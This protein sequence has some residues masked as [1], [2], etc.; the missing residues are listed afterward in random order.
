M[1]K[2]LLAAVS[3]SALIACNPEKDMVEAVV[4]DTG[5]I[6]GAG[7]GYLLVLPDSALLKPV[8]LDAAFRHHNLPVKVEYTYSGIKDTCDYGAKVFEMVTISK[9]KKDI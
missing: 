2:L 8:H 1:K 5:D 6:T 3:I 7:C 4:L 9:I